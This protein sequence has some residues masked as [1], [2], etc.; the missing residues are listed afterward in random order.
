MDPEPEEK[1]ITNEIELQEVRRRSVMWISKK[2]LACTERWVIR[3]RGDVGD[4]KST[5]RSSI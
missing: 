4:A 3:E 1:N 2:K 5:N